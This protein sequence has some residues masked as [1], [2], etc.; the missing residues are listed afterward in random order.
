MRTLLYS[1]K[2]TDSCL[3]YHLPE[4]RNS[5]AVEGLRHPQY[6]VADRP[7]SWQKQVDIK[8]H[9]SFMR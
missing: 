1:S 2:N 9:L 4:I 3:N 5:A 7:R 6:S 8:N